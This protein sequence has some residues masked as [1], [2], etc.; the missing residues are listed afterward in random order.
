MVVAVGGGASTGRKFGDIQGDQLWDGS[1]WRKILHIDLQK[2]ILNYRG[3]DT[4]S[5]TIAIPNRR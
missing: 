5:R 1:G 3:E 4:V 2:N